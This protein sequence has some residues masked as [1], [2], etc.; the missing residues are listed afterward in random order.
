MT[1]TKSFASSR[2]NKNSQL[3]A[4]G[5]TVEL[6]LQGREHLFAQC[7]ESSG[8]VQGEGAHAAIVVVP[9]NQGSV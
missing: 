9:K 6:A 5:Q 2:N 8:P 1:R 4:F 7:V 3:L